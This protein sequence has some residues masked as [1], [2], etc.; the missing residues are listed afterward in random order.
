MPEYTPKQFWKLYEKLPEELREAL[1]SEE[2]SNA[3][4]QSC[5]KNQVSEENALKISEYV[6][7][8]LAGLLPPAEL[9]DALEK[10]LKLKKSVAK[11]VAREINRFVFYPVKTSLEKL[12]AI[13]LAR[14]AEPV[15]VAPPP[16][17]KPTP[18][19]GKDVYREP[20]E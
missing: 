14:P 20:A 5:E 1:F 4:Y 7:K 18:L 19:P 10:E 9:Q 13:E 2:T 15:K 11:E 8:V 12:Y 6:G 3:V 17:E 16:E